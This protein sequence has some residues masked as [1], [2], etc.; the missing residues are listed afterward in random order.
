MRRG[1]TC[2][3]TRAEPASYAPKATLGERRVQN[4]AGG[5]GIP[6]GIDNCIFAFPMIPLPRTDI[7]FR[8]NNFVNFQQPNQDLGEWESTTEG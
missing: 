4:K 3:L 1:F 2:P 6:V 8:C 7:Y 5:S